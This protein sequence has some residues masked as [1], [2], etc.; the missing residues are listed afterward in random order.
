MA[1]TSKFSMRVNDKTQQHMDAL[2]DWARE[3]GMISYQSNSDVVKLALEL[4]DEFFV[5]P[6]M[7]NPENDYSTLKAKYTKQS[8]HTFN[9]MQS[10]L[11]LILN[12]QEL[13]LILNLNEFIQDDNLSS[14]EKLAQ[15][16][17]Y[18]VTD[19]MQSQV[20]EK[21]DEIM[22]QDKITRI[23]KSKEN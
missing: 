7:E 5:Q 13:S 18:L 2:K 3:N 11:Q 15:L 9:K 10:M 8:N 19:S 12:N 17:S 16:Q 6:F 22:Q 21:I 1:D 20:L 23:K 14:Q 4:A